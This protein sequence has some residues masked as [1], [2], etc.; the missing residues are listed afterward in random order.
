MTAEKYSEMVQE[1]KD[2]IG[3]DK[4]SAEIQAQFD[5]QIDSFFASKGFVIVSGNTGANSDEDDVQN[6]DERPNPKSLSGNEHETSHRLASDNNENGD[7]STN[8]NAELANNLN[9]GKVGQSENEENG[10]KE[11]EEEEEVK[12]QE[13]EQEVKEQEDEEQESDVNDDIDSGEEY[14]EENACEL[15]L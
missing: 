1:M 3:Y 6:R 10:S 12:E 9:V 11:Q 7:G 14:D 8:R 2:A 4:L 5:S 13:E 15:E